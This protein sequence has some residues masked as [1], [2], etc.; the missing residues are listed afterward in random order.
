MTPKQAIFYG[1]YIK[2]ENATRAAIAAGFPP[3]SAHVAGSRML[4]NAKVQAAIEDWKSRQVAKLELEADD[5]LRELKKILKCDVKNLYDP[6]TGNRIPVHLLDDFTRAAVAGVEDETTESTVGEVTTVRRNQRVKMADKLRAAEL[7]G[8]YFK[9]YTDK[10]EVG[11]VGGGPIPVQ[12]AIT[13][14]FVDP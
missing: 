5:V 2:D 7:L 4:K 10:S 13:V 14:T 12:Q 1:E 8:K 3:A 6:V 11:G 9:L